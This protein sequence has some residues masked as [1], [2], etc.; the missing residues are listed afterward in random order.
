MDNS[1]LN[2]ELERERKKLVSI[3]KDSME[4]GLPITVNEKILEQSRKV[5]ALIVRIQEEKEKHR[6]NQP[7]R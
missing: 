5:D 1:K 3:I 2:I 6:N 7:E 4:R